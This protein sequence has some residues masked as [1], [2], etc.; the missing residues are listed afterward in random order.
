MRSLHSMAAAL[1]RPAAAALS[2]V[3]LTALLLA[4][5]A[6]ERRNAP[7]DA[8]AASAERPSAVQPTP[9]PRRDGP[10]ILMLGDSLTAGHGLPVEQ[11]FPSLIQER[12]R[13]AGYPHRVVNAGVSG[14]TSAGG[15]ARLD[16]LLRQRVDI[17]L[18]A[19]GANDGLRAQD[20]AAMHANLAR[21]IERAQA[22]GIRVL[23]AGMRMPS[24]YGPDYTRRYRRTFSDLAQRYDLP[25]IPFL[26][27]G[28]AADPA[29]NQADGIHPN[30]AGTRIVADTVWAVLEPQLQR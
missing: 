9:E 26:L 17:L 28:V 3:M 29:L 30:A 20:P 14:D 24:N 5:P 23:L 25:F 18:L 6:C 8:P 16:W 7:A 27:E 11:A 4:V 1:A 21:I 12:L 2:A 19:L 13:A 15:L 10:V 22:A